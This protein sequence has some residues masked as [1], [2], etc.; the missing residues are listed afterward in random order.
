MEAIFTE[1]YVLLWALVLALALFLPV[2]RLIWLLYMR[3]AL[4]QGEPDEGE[5]QR[6]KKRATATAVLICFVFS[7]LYTAQ[8]LQGPP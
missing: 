2:R 5:S 8:L 6:L 1:R 4:R 7:L 3:R